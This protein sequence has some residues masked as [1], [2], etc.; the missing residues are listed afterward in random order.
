MAS[1]HDWR[2]NYDPDSS[3]EEDDGEDGGADL[4][5]PTDSHPPSP[6]LEAI[7]E[8]VIPENSLLSLTLLPS[9][10]EPPVKEIKK[11]RGNTISARLQ[12]LTLFTIDYKQAPKITT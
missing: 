6:L 9:I 4:Y 1:F 10:Q 3:D 8:E 2:S 12:A 5:P 7:Q 11:K